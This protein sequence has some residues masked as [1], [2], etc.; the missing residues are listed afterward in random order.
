MQKIFNIFVSPCGPFPLQENRFYILNFD[1]SVFDLE[2]ICST[3]LN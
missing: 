2:M 3:I 1:N